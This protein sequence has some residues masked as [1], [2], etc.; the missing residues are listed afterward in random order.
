MQGVAGLSQAGPGRASVPR[1]TT[2]QGKPLPTAMLAALGIVYG[3]IGTS[4]LYTLQTVVQ[5]F[6]HTPGA[7]DVLGALSMIFWALLITVSFKYCLL[8]M[9]AD[10]HGEGGILMLMSLLGAYRTGAAVLT[11][12]GLFG[13]ALIYGDGAVTPAISVLSALEGLNVL[14]D[15]AKPFI[16][17]GAVVILA[18]LF[19]AQSLGTAAI[20]RAFGPVMAL[21]FAVIGVIGAVHI[22]RDPAVL[23][24][25]NP[26]YAIHSFMTL[27]WQGFLVLGAVVLAITGGE[28]LYA[29]M[30]HVGRRPIRVSWFGIVLPCLLLSYAGQAAVLTHKPDTQDNPFFTAFD[31]LHLGHGAL[32]ALVVLATIATIIASQSIIT[33]AF[34]LTRQAMQLGWFPGLRI[35]QTSTEEHGQIYVPV[36]NWTMMVATLGLALAFRSSA[37]LSTAYGTAVSTT[38]LLTTLLLIVLM[39]RRWRWS[40]FAIVPVGGLLGVVDLAFFAG[41]MLKLTDGGWVPLAMGAAI[42]VLMTTWRRGQR[43]IGERLAQLD[44]SREALMAEL[45]AGTLARTPGTGIFLTGSKRAIPEPMR[46][47]ASQVRALPRTAIALSVVFSDEPYIFSDDKVSLEPTGP[48]L[49]KIVATFGFAEIPSLKSAL[50]LAARKGCPVDAEHVIFYSSAEDVIAAPDRAERILP[51]WQRWLFGLLRRNAV[52]PVDLLSLPRERYLALSRQI[53]L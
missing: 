15:A 28:A 20:G 35:R 31:E 49:F 10:V 23:A 46:L 45:V 32:I 47:L 11:T 5:S 39:R 17:P 48:G 3:D 6:G 8:A 52:R 25:A 40:W 50:D 41:N 1:M 30:G 44:E 13:A 18:G 34:S 36:V 7:A 43:A 33:G 12:M 29:D 26:T 19:A 16:L 4:P 51:A 24:A 2:R 22:A 53:E 21:W 14:T 37:R 42:F 38:M 27:K 9:R